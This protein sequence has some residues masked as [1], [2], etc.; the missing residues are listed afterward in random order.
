MECQ[1][2]LRDWKVLTGGYG[3]GQVKYGVEVLGLSGV[4]WTASRKV[5][6][7]SGH[8]LLYS[9]PPNKGEHHRNGVGFMLTKNANRSP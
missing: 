5:T 4:R 7:E 3:D 8:V 9:G 2:F 1:N 6:L